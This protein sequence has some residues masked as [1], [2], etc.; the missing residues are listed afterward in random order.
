MRIPYTRYK[1]DNGQIESLPIVSVR[2]TH[3]GKSLKIGALV[4]S[5][6]DISLFNADIATLLCI[7]P[8]T[9][10]HYPIG[11]FAGGPDM[12]VWLHPIELTLNEYPAIAINVAFTNLQM[13]ELCILGQRGFFDNFQIRFERYKD[14]MEIF[15]KS[16]SI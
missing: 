15:P 1:L 2:L 6:A 5:G 11:T 9:G 16:T 12:D 4:D 14:L 10:K 13:P 8:D 7:I 3:K